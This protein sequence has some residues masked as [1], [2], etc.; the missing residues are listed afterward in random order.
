MVSLLTA[1]D[2]SLDHPERLSTAGRPR[3]GVDVRL[4]AV[5]GTVLPDHEQGVIEVRLRGMSSGYIGRPGDPAFHDGWYTTGDLGF[6]DRDG[7]LHVRGRAADAR[8]ID[9]VPVLPLDLEEAACAHPEVV[10][11]VAL[12]ATPDR[13]GRSACWRCGPTARRWRRPT[14]APISSARST[15]PPLWATSSS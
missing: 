8:D 6:L 10:Y 11:A 9:G 1:P 14:C 2:Y 12:P 5:D 15:R 13:T 7:Y 4:V 3:P